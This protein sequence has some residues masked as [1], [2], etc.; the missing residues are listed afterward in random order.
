MQEYGVETARLLFERIDNPDGAFR[1]VILP[2]RMVVR[3][4]CGC[5]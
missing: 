2:A 5:S 3:E 4:S 1:Q